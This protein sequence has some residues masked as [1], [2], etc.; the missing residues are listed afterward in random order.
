M[1]FSLQKFVLFLGGG[2]AVERNVYVLKPIQYLSFIHTT[3]DLF[4]KTKSSLSK[5]PFF[6]F[7]DTQNTYFAV[8]MA[9]TEGKCLSKILYR[10]I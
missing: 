7:L 2:G 9:Q 4:F 8:T 3:N 6:Q 10:Q 1:M 5:E